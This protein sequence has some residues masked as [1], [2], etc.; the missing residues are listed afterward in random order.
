[1]EKNIQS[2]FHE[3]TKVPYKD[4]AGTMIRHNQMFKQQL[5]DAIDMIYEE[6]GIA[7]N[8]ETHNQPMKGFL[9]INEKDILKTDDIEHI[10]KENIPHLAQAPVRFIR[11]KET[12]RFR[13]KLKNPDRNTHDLHGQQ[14]IVDPRVIRLVEELEKPNNQLMKHLNSS[15]FTIEIDNKYAEPSKHG[16]RGIHIDIT[17]NKASKEAGEHN[18]TQANK[19]ARAELQ[20]HTPRGVRAYLG[21]HSIYKAYDALKD[22]VEADEGKNQNNWTEAQK[23]VVYTLRK[24]L[25][26]VY[27]YA[28]HED[29]LIDRLNEDH[30]KAE[31]KNAE[32]ALK[33]IVE[34]EDSAFELARIFH[35]DLKG[36]SASMIAYAHEI[37]ESVK[38]K[39]DSPSKQKNE[40]IP[41]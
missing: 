25:K 19:V 4:H 24:Y 31:F 14:V 20:F 40:L 37:V 22:Q 33:K 9:G 15:G 3:T 1:M 11:E 16:Y 26:S 10:L 5:L 29:G 13:Q 41:A 7:S 18:G 32:Q 36:D 27:E 2:T 8:H 38:S 12:E 35:H 6:V 23:D 30:A 21:T 28:A 39:Q 34:L 17:Y